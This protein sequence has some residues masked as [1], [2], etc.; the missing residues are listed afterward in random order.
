[1]L[2]QQQWYL[3]QDNFLTEFDALIWTKIPVF[4][5]QFN[6]AWTF[7]QTPF[8]FSQKTSGDYIFP[9]SLSFVVVTEWRNFCFPAVGCTQS[10]DWVREKTHVHNNNKNSR[11]LCTRPLTVLFRLSGS[12]TRE[13]GWPTS[14]TKEAEETGHQ[15]LLKSREERE[16]MM[17]RAIDWFMFCWSAESNEC[18]SM[19]T[20]P[21]RNSWKDFKGWISWIRAVRLSNQRQSRWYVRLWCK[22]IWRATHES[23]HTGLAAGRLW[24]DFVLNDC[25]KSDNFT[26]NTRDSYSHFT[27]TYSLTDFPSSW[28]IICM[29]EQSDLEKNRR[30]RKNMDL[31]PIEAGSDSH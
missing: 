5:F 27:S 18:G 6:Y 23:L 12:I 29:H 9:V 21:T 8:S 31:K 3:V 22:N 15:V 16:K 17:R 25:L 30:K 7:S 13:S 20:T 11:Q 10:S 26:L 4:A 1:M 2:G 24:E 14:E 19:K 28:D